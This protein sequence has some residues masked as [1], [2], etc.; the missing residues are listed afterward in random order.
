MRDFMSGTRLAIKNKSKLASVT[1]SMM[2]KVHPQ[3]F[4]LNSK[5]Y[6]RYFIDA[7]IVSASVNV[8]LKAVIL[9]EPLHPYCAGKKNQCI[10]SYTNP[11]L[12]WKRNSLTSISCPCTHDH[13]TFNL[14]MT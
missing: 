2:C 13:R 5:H 7:A 11:S 4:P 1:Y 14:A 10:I 3:I 6:F 12:C 8:P 9:N